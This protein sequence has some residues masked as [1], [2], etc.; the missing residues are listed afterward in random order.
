[1]DQP[2]PNTQPEQLVS[3]ATL[4]PVDS[5]DTAAHEET[6]LSDEFRDFGRQLI[7]AL[8]SVATSDELRNLGNEIVESLRDI[9]EEVQET[10][11]RTRDKEEVKAVGEQ[12]RRVTQAVSSGIPAKDMAADVQS[13]LSQAL[14]SL[15]AELNK[16]VDQIQSRSARVSDE[17]ES[18]AHEAADKASD[19]VD[20]AQESASNVADRS[21][22]PDE[23]GAAVEQSGVATDTSQGTSQDAATSFGTETQEQNQAQ[24]DENEDDGLAMLEQAERESENGV[25]P[26]SEIVADIQGDGDTPHQS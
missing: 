4:E 5:G 18:T 20:S 15:N 16:V 14:R 1:M 13:S 25:R 6:R 22:P 17:V 23:V 12:A 9:G 24:S 26:L 11:E 8:R 3:E 7:R 21:G 19:A 2:E 10:L